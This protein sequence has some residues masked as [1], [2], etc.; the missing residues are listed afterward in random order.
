MKPKPQGESRFRGPRMHGWVEVENA[1]F[2]GGPDLPACRRDGQQWPVGMS[3]KWQAWRS[4][5]HARLWGEADWQYASDTA[6]L[7]ASAFQEGAKIG[8][9]AELRF[10]E[11]QMGTTWS[12]RQDMRIRYVA[13]ADAGVPPATITSLEQYRDL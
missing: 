5:P 7:A 2:D 12:A 8:L 9:L 3:A 4:L 11:K 1:P 13:P 10:R 6:E